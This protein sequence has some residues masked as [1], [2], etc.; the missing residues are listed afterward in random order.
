MRVTFYRVPLVPSFKL[1]LI[2]DVA[3]L[4]GFYEVIQR[5]ID[6][7]GDTVD[8]MDVLSLG[9]ALT[10]HV[11]DDDPDSPG[12]VFVESAAMVRVRLAVAGPPGRPLSRGSIGSETVTDDPGV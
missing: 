9:A 10:H 12:S 8:A 6:L 7:N 5:P 3:A 1:Y 2:N 11:K 4:H